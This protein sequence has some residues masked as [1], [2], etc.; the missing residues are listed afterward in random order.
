V[1]DKAKQYAEISNGAFDV[2]IGPLV[3]AWGVFTDNPRVPS[4]MKLMS[5]KTGKL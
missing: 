1:L 2:T 4:K 3:K 5:F